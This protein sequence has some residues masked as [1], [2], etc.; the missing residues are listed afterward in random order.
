MT[1]LETVRAYYSLF[2]RPSRDVLD[3]VV[4]ED[5]KL[6]DNPI[7]WHIRGKADLWRTVDR[8]R[9]AAPGNEPPAFV[10]LDYVGDATRGAARWH[11]RVRGGGAALFGATPGDA[12]AEVDGVAY[13][14][15]RDGQLAS[16]TEYWDAASVMRQLGMNVYQPRFPSPAGSA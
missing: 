8:P 10:V 14:E 9:P 3:E 12:V 1:P 5:F 6:D 4:A 2:E 13:V 7:D 16:L 11:W 15:F